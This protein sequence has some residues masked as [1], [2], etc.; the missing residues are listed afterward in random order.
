VYVGPYGE[1]FHLVRAKVVN[2]NFRPPSRPLSVKEEE[3][4]VVEEEKRVVKGGNMRARLREAM[5]KKLAL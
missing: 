2:P 3:V 1:N 4:P 5:R